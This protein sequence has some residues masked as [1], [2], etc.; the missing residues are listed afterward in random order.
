MFLFS[1]YYLYIQI[2]LNGKKI[3]LKDLREVKGGSTPDPNAREVCI[4]AGGE[5]VL[6]A[7]GSN[8]NIKC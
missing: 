4:C 8:C 7:V 5:L 3:S 6:A 1:M 2:K